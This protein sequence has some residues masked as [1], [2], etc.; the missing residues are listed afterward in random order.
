MFRKLLFLLGF[1]LPWAMRRRWFET[2]LG[3]RIHATARIGLA[4]VLPDRLIMEEQSRIGHLTVCKG[5]SLVHLERFAS[6]GRANWIYGFNR[7]EGKHYSHQ[8]DRISKLVLREHSAITN[9]HLIDCT[10]AVT[11]G[12]F[13]II[14]GYRSQIL[15]HSID[16]G[17]CRQSSEPITVRDYCFTGTGVVIL[18]GSVLPNYPVLGA[19]SL[20]KKA[21]A[22]G[23]TL[24]SGVPARAIKTLHNSLEYFHRQIGF[25]RS[26]YRHSTPNFLR[27]DRVV[28][29]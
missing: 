1:L 14:A 9:R 5:M 23:Y 29:T 13:T 7:G 16:L 17:S 15:T 11:I 12:K 25:V 19:M 20:L 6:I 27:T 3:Y 8:R 18:G 2:A 22:Q 28:T 21:F 24:Y 10:N 26:T 4:W